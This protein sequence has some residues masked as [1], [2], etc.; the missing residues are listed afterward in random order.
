M[1]QQKRLKTLKPVSKNLTKDYNRAQR[2]QQIE[3]FLGV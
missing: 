3:T 2:F 1:S